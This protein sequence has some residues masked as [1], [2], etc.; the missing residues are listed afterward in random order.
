MA[1]IQK[2]AKIGLIVLA[3]VAGFF[4]IKYLQGRPKEVTIKL[5]K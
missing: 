1:Q 3:L 5:Q 4:G 2:P